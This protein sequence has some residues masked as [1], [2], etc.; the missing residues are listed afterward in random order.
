[1]CP[2]AVLLEKDGVV[3]MTKNP[4]PPTI[5]DEVSETVVL[6]EKYILWNQGYNACMS[7]YG[8]RIT[9]LTEKFKAEIKR[10]K[11]PQGNIN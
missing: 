10:L 1:M 5:V 11:Q 8:E 2:S 7:V 4:Y 3:T 9:E 6:N